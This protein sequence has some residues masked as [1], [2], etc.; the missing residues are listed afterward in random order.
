MFSN[1]LRLDGTAIFAICVGS[2]VYLSVPD[3]DIGGGVGEWGHKAFR[4]FVWSSGNCLCS[5]RRIT[6]PLN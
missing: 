6:G 2:S 1:I 5:R 3:H 4:S